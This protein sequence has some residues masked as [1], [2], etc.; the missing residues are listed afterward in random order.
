MNDSISSAIYRHLWMC[1]FSLLLWPDKTKEAMPDKKTV[2]FMVRR[3]AHCQYDQWLKQSVMAGSSLWTQACY[4]DSSNWTHLLNIWHVYLWLPMPKR[5]LPQ[6]Q[7]ANSIITDNTPDQATKRL[8]WI[9]RT[10][11]R[12]EEIVPP[13]MAWCE[14]MQAALRTHDRS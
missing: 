4:T 9:K 5:R 10:R 2:E 6:I 13:K 11:G 7:N 12:C 8:V 14:R 3:Q 1:H